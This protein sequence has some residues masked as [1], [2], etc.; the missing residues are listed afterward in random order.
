VCGDFYDFVTVAGGGI[1][2]V[3]GDVCGV[4][5]AAANDAAFAR[6]T[7]RSFVADESDPAPLMSKLNS[8]I[9]RH[10]SSDR[11]VRL[12]LGVLDPERAELCYVNAGH[13]PPVVY[14]SAAGRVEWLSEGELPLG[15]VPEQ[16]YEAKRVLLEPGDMLVFYADGVTEGIRKGRVFGQGKLQDLVEEYGVGTPGELVQAIRRSVEAWAPSDEL[17]D[18]VA[19]LVCQVASDAAIA[20]PTREL[21]LPNEPARLRELRAFVAGYLADLRAP[22]EESQEVIIAVGEA[23]SNACKYGRSAQGRSELRV[24]CALEGPDIVISVSDDGPGFDP[25]KTHRNGLPDRFASGGRGMF[26]MHQFMDSVEFST[27][28]GGTTVTLKRAM[29]VGAGRARV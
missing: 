3:L 16:R 12:V 8:H 5:P 4:G 27:S 15:V 14:R 23:A 1:G 13:V 18:D 25:A 22:I 11:F 7:L 19:L 9:G 10:L 6:Y 21:L 2:V 28:E 29:A 24:R 26:L 17:R 20:E